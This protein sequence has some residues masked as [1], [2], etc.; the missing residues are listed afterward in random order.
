MRN[1]NACIAVYDITR[2]STFTGLESQ[3][4]DFLNYADNMGVKHNINFYDSSRERKNTTSNLGGKKIQKQNT[5]TMNKE[6][7]AAPVFSDNGFIF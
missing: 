6:R 7:K 5:A 1:A 4:N 3:I 2:R